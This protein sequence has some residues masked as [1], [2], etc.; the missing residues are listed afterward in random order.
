MIF[1]V[2]SYLIAVGAP[3]FIID[4][5]AEFFKIQPARGGEV[6]EEL[7]IQGSHMVSHTRC[8]AESDP[9]KKWSESRAAAPKGRCPVEH[10]GEFRDV[11]PSVCP[12]TLRLRPKS[13][14]NQ[15][16]GGQNLQMKRWNKVNAL[17]RGI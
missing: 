2:L 12:E 16:I 1:K 6:G 10:S 11:R 9:V 14:Q 15:G 13:G 3:F 7:V 8:P 17:G 5:E 4:I